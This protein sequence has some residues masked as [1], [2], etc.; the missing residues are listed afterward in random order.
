M[1]SVS[2]VTDVKPAALS[3]F[4]ITGGNLEDSKEALKLAEIRGNDNKHK[5]VPWNK[6]HRKVSGRF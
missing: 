5:R 2:F 6:C 4:M 1:S 3:Q